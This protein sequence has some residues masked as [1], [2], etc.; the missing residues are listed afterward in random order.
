MPCYLVDLLIWRLPR[1]RECRFRIYWV[2]VY[3]CERE[4]SERHPPECAPPTIP[5]MRHDI[6]YSIRGATAGI[7]ASPCIAQSPFR[8]PTE[9]VV[10]ES[11]SLRENTIFIGC[12]AANIALRPVASFGSRIAIPKC[13]SRP[14]PRITHTF[15]VYSV[16]CVYVC[17][18]VSLYFFF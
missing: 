4:K 2:L 3:V 11:S 8:V 12:R 5:H 14:S 6:M 1:C 9:L 16:R 13:K 10:R 18:V 17:H 15:C 7:A